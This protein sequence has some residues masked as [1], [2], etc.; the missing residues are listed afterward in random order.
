MTKKI[1][2]AGATGR[3]GSCI[4]SAFLGTEKSAFDVSILSR[5]SSKPPKLDERVHVIPVDYDN[6]DDLVKV[7]KGQDILISCIASAQNV[8]TDYKLLDA[9]IE[10]KVSRFFPNEWS[11][12][13]MHPAVKETAVDTRFGLKI[14]FAEKLEEYARKGKIEYTAIVTGQFVDEELVDG[15]LGPVLKD[16]T[17]TYYDGGKY[18]VTGCSLR[19]V[20]AAVVKMASKSGGDV[21]NKRIRIAEMEYTGKQVASLLGK[22]SGDEFTVKEDITSEESLK[23]C[24]AELE[25]GE[26]LKAYFTAI[27]RLNFDGSGAGCFIDGLKWS[28]LPRKSLEE[29]VRSVVDAVKEGRNVS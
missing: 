13:C 8:E 28:D 3:V 27:K 10:A 12:D 20:G 18:K 14:V 2:I 24:K 4:L 25:A 26:E 15:W 16:R 29:Q 21:K 23:K 6:H 19:F 22:V 5:K 11:L 1:V 17:V 7:L 9:A